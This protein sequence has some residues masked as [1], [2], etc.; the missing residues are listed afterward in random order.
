LDG[1]AQAGVK[2]EWG[3][4]GGSACAPLEALV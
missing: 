3:E 4:C 2:R 1:L